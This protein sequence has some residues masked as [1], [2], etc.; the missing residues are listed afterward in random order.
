MAVVF[1]AIPDLPELFTPGAYRIDFVFVS[2]SDGKCQSDDQDF[3]FATALSHE[4]N[5]TKMYS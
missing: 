2:S 3:A 4:R 5:G 1:S